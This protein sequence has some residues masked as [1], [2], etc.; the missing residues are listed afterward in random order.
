MPCQSYPACHVSFSW[1]PVTLRRSCYW[2]FLILSA[3][4]VFHFWSMRDVQYIRIQPTQ[5]SLQSLQPLQSDETSDDIPKLLWYKLGPMGLRDDTRTWTNSCI[6]ANPDYRA[7]FMT[8]E[9]ADEYVK[10]AYVM[11]PDIVENYL[12]LPIPIL[13]ADM[14]R[15]LLLFDQG[16]VYADLDVSCEGVPMDQWVPERYKANASVVVG[17]E[18]DMGFD[19]NILLEFQSWTIMAKPHSPHIL[20]VI[21]DL[22]D[23][24]EDTKE[25]HKVTVDKIALDMIG[26]VVDFSGPRR[27]T[28]GILKSLKRQLNREIDGKEIRK[29]YQ[30]KL[31][32]DV[33]IMPGYSFAATQNTYQPGDELKMPPKLVQHHY[34]GTWKNKNGGETVNQE[35][36]PRHRREDA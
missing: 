20:Q 16:G 35:M 32:G 8:D 30:P 4:A 29:I 13:K 18:F 3:I 24:I 27:L 19:D 22:I 31:V 36:T 15:Y 33:L 2:I 17:W 7:T 1:Q 10:K 21:D 25:K 5:Q 34:A 12:G 23:A 28:Y 6:T 11:R 14:L 26:D 9:T